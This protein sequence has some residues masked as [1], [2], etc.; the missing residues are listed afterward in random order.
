M[1]RFQ[2]NIVIQHMD[3]IR[4]F[5]RFFFGEEDATEGFSNQKLADR[6]VECFKMRMKD[7]SLNDSL[8]YDMNFLMLVPPK[9]FDDVCVHLPILARSM[10]R[11][12]YKVIDTERVK[13]P[14][15]TPLT[16]FWT[17]R[18]APKDISELGEEGDIAIFG[19]A[20]AEKTWGETFEQDANLGSVSINGRHSAY[21]CF[22]LNQSLFDGVDT[23]ERG[24][25]RI[26]FN[27]NLKLEDYDMSGG[28]T[29]EPKPSP[30]TSSKEY[31]QITFN[32]INGSRCYMMRQK[33]L[34]IGKARDKDDKPSTERL[35]IQIGD[36]A[37]STEHFYL[38]YNEQSRSLSLAIFAPAT[39]NGVPHTRVSTH[40]QIEWIPLKQ[41]TDI[42]CGTC[43]IEILAK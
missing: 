11:E 25:L 12:F 17:F 43:H 13:R 27:R 7:C 34:S 8:I 2:C 5:K 37:L 33:M 16:N 30:S 23:L 38:A 42:L 22:N 3:I 14:L 21:S 41:K 1:R 32:S 31:A 28:N 39:I 15:Y 18:V 35:P 24:C 36:A 4:I 29:P 26:V 40:S 10:V 19:Q 6:V 20:T 9:H